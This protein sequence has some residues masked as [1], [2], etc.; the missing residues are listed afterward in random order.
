MRH[1]WPYSMSCFSMIFIGKNVEPQILN[2]GS[3]TGQK[4]C[5]A[6][7]KNDRLIYRAAMVIIIHLH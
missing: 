1:I 4:N 3:L 6:N 5:G 7:T 2:C